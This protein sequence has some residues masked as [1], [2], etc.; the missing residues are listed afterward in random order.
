MKRLWAPMSFV[1]LI[2][3]LPGCA[4]TYERGPCIFSETK[5]GAVWDEQKLDDA[6]QL[7]C[8]SG[9]STLVIVTDGE[10]VKSLGDLDEPL[11]VHSV[12]K[13]WD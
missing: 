7:A 13:A 5:T 9:T 6:F 8:A 1:L 10:F 3:M 2:L 12:R 4:S 11:R